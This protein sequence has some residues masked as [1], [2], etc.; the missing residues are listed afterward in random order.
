[1]SYQPLLAERGMRVLTMAAGFLCASVACW[2]AQT[3]GRCPQ[4]VLTRSTAPACGRHNRGEDCGVCG[5]LGA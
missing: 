4:P 1:M 3:R 5:A 2:R